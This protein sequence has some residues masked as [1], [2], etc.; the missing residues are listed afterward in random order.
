MKRNVASCG[1][2]GLIKLWEASGNSLE[3]KAD[4]DYHTDA[5]RSILTWQDS[6]LSCS[7][8]Q[9]AAH[10]MNADG[11]WELQAS[12]STPSKVLSMEYFQVNSDSFVVCG[13]QDGTMISYNLSE[14][15]RIQ[16][17]LPVHPGAVLKI[18]HH[19]KHTALVL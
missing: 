19:D 6:I 8:S 14:P 3:H 2:D 9:V 1:I 7:G 18:T 4:I 10:T 12:I 13:F 16:K 17:F 15:T 11:E 5:V